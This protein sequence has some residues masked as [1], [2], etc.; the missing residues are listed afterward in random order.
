MKQMKFRHWIELVLSFVIFGFVY[1]ILHK[2][3]IY[4]YIINQFG[5]VF[6]ILLIIF[7]LLLCAGLALFIQ[8]SV[9][10][11]YKKIKSTLF[12]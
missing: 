1:Y 9:I 7:T 4:N 11:L 5:Y 10:S 8:E 12:K 6:L 2:T 3:A